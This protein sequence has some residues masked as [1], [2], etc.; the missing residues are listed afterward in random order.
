MGTLLSKRKTIKQP[1][2]DEKETGLLETPKK[3]LEP[4]R[5][6]TENEKPPAQ[7]PYEA[8]VLTVTEQ[9]RLVR[10]GSI[11]G[12]PGLIADALT[13]GNIL[14]PS[15]IERAL[16]IQDEWEHGRTTV[17]EVLKWQARM[18]EGAMK[19]ARR[20]DFIDSSQNIEEQQPH[21][22]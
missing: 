20:E 16:A 4:I 15:H 17:N 2:L 5:T 13:K 9:R 19:L 6:P 21:P 3:S 12:T 7:T 18:E 22:R 1:T 8:R 11:S 10:L 14:D